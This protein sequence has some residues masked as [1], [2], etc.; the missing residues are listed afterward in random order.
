MDSVADPTPGVVA[1]LLDDLAPP[2]LGTLLRTARKH[3]ELTRREVAGRVGT[4]PSELRRFERGETPVPPRVVAALAECYGEDLTAQFATRDPIQFD[5]SRIVVGTEEAPVTS[6]DDDEIL[7]TYVGI[8]A[9]LRHAKPGEPIALRA[10][11]L[12]ALSTALGHAP[13]HIEAR[14]A[15]LL[16][17]TPREARSLHSELLRRKL[18]LPVAGLVTGL[19]VVT[20]VGVSVAAAAPGS[21]AHNAPAP[22]STVVPTTVAPVAQTPT[23]VAPAPAAA[24]TTT[25]A[26]A[27]P[28]T[29]V[30]PAAAPATAPAVAPPVIAPDDTPVGIPANETVTIIWP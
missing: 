17:C 26:A 2:R 20:G 6:E 4:T 3:H 29:E 10:A 18:V 7:G 8:V 14:I 15:E 23:T 19:A 11:D 12:V 13:E 21:P 16:G 27:P 28:T 30:A 24:P 9:Q 1:L 22:Y 5:R 25:V